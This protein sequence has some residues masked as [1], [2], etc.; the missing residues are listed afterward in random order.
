LRLET[1]ISST[2]AH[3]AVVTQTAIRRV[4]ADARARRNAVNSIS[5]QRRDDG[6]EFVS[7]RS[8]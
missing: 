2:T 3:V 5:R 8:G 7:D 1:A 6:G 4:S